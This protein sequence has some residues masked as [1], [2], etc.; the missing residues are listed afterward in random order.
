MVIYKTT[1][2]INGKYYIGKQKCYT[3]T[4]LG[5]GVALKYAI[6]KYGRKNFKK[7]ILEVCGSESELQNKELEWLDK[8]GAVKD[9]QCYN[10]VRETSPNKHRSYN[11]PN[12]RK[13]LSQTV[14]EAMHRPDVYSKIVINNGGMN[15]PMYGKKRSESFKKMISWRHTGKRLSDETKSL[16]A[17]SR[18]GNKASS[19]TK[20]KM[21]ISQAKRWD[22]IEIEV[23]LE[24]GVKTFDCRT[25]FLTFVREYNSDIPIGRVKGIGKRRINWKRA[26]K[27]GY[28]FI[29][30]TPK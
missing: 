15:N 2:L 19:E 14:K 8:L 11:D 24:R 22:T 10:L 27:N 13:T 26:L 9:K 25:D 30:V 20:H 4:Y 7:E 23:H 3:I 21:K 18:R 1:N 17:L 6:G 28:D 12:Y 5:S 16:I 29:L